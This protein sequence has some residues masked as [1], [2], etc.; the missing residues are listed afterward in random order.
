M[1]L[2]CRGYM[3]EPDGAPT[4]AHWPAPF[5][6]DVAAPMIATLTRVLQASLDFALKSRP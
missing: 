5:D 6:A 4:E 3:A 2:A 1:E